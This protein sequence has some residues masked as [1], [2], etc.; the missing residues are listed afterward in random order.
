M[1]ISQA[2]AATCTPIR[3][4]LFG[5]PITESGRRDQTGVDGGLVEGDPVYEAQGSLLLSAIS[6][7]AR[8]VIAIAIAIT[9]AIT[10]AID[11]SYY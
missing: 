7:S 8:I 5:S 1:L 6:S 3:L 9:I 2:M 4:R 10:I 11:N